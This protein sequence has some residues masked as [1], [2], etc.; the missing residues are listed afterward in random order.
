MSSEPGVQAHAD[1]D[2][3]SPGKERAAPGQIGPATISKSPAEDRP[4]GDVAVRVE[5]LSKCYQVYDRPQDRLKQALVPKLQRL[6]APLTGG[7]W[8]RPLTPRR[9]FR[10]FWALRDVSFDVGRGEAVGVLG[11][12]GSGKSTLLQL[13]CET[14]AP[15]HGEVRVNGRVA[16]LLEL[17]AGFNME[18]TGRENVFTN[19]AILGMSHKETA[20]RFDEIAA[21]ADIG[22]FIDQPI[23]SYSSG[24]YLRLAFSVAISV[25][26][27]I[28][29][30]D[31]ALSVGD[32]GF[33]FKCAERIQQLR[34]AGVTLL[35]VSHDFGMVKAICDRAIYLA[36]GAIKAEGPADEV[37]ELYLMDVREQQTSAATSAAP[38]ERK[39]HVTKPDG[40]AFGTDAGWIIDATF[41]DT[42]GPQACFA[43]GEA[44]AICAEL[45]FRSSLRNPA[46]SVIVNDRR[47]IPILGRHFRLSR[48]GADESRFRRVAVECTF[49][50]PLAEGQYFITI[51]LED[52]PTAQ[53]VSVV[54]KQSGALSFQMLREADSESLGLVDVPM[55][56]S[57]RPLG[58][59]TEETLL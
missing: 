46:F 53:H 14:L 42:G 6:A 15:T 47:M 17:G 10:E 36:Q 5:G 48:A 11:L 37:A 8:R 33:Q 45:K 59:G 51:R 49:P 1:E 38:I 16:A 29:I 27:D 54:D 35:F 34:K 52:R 40:V 28:L 3:A 50:S 12:N 24:M 21:F 39:Q 26:P 18:F 56:F 55:E 19:A 58:D 7:I 25:D 41:A 43:R 13:V 20:A 4:E 23:K 31:E 22:D 44:I 57:E 9:Y 2:A 30:I 32:A